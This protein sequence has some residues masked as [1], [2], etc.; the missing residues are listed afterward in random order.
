MLIIATGLIVII[1]VLAL[2]FIQAG[3]LTA[4]WSAAA[5]RRD[6]A[7]SAA[8]DGMEYAMARLRQTPEAIPGVSQTAANACDDWTFRDGT[9]AWT[10]RVSLAASPGPS[11]IRGEPWTDNPL[12]PNFQDDDGD[13]L[14][15]ETG[16]GTGIFNPAVD[17]WA[18]VDGDG[19]FTAYS[20]RLRG[21]RTPFSRLF[22]LRVKA[23]QSM[24]CVNSG[25]LGLS[26][27]DQD[28]DGILNESDDVFN[29]NT[30]PQVYEVFDNPRSTDGVYQVDP[31]G[32]PNWK[33]PSFYP[34]AH[35]VNILNNLGT[36]LAL[37]LPTHTENML[38]GGT[39][40]VSD[41]GRLVIGNRPRGGYSSIEELWPI[42]ENAGLTRSQFD[43]LAP[44]L[45]T[46]GEIVPVG[47]STP[48]AINPFSDYAVQRE[49]WIEFHAR[50]DLNNVPPPILQAW[51]Y[52]MA[53]S[54]S[55]WDLLNPYIP[56]SKIIPGDG[57]L[58]ADA[59][60]KDRP[61]NTWKRLLNTVKQTTLS[62]TA[63]VD[64][65]LIGDL[66]LA[67]ADANS[68]VVDPFSWRKSCLDVM[69][70][71]SPRYGNDT[72]VM[73][74]ISRSL[75][76]TEPFV[77]SVD[78]RVS[79]AATFAAS[80]QIYTVESEGC[81]RREGGGGAEGSR[82][83]RSELDVGGRHILLTSQQ[84][85]ERLTRTLSDPGASDIWRSPGGEVRTEGPCQ[86]RRGIQSWPRFPLTGPILTKGDT[87]IPNYAPTAIDPTGTFLGYLSGVPKS[88]RYPSHFGDL[89]LS[90]R[91]LTDDDLGAGGNGC[92]F[93]LPFNEDAAGNAAYSQSLY[94]D[95]IAD[96]L[97]RS[98]TPAEF[99][100]SQDPATPMVLD[101][102]PIG[103]EQFLQGIQYAPGGVRLVGALVTIPTGWHASSGSHQIYRWNGTGA[104]GFPLLRADAVDPNTGVTVPGG[105]EI[106]AGTIEFWI[107]Q[108]AGE[109]SVHADYADADTTLTCE[110][111]GDDGTGDGWVKYFTIEIDYRPP[112]FGAGSAIVGKFF[113][114]TNNLPTDLSAPSWPDKEKFNL[115][116]AGI[117]ATENPVG[118]PTWRHVAVAFEDNGVPG[119]FTS[120][121]KVYIDG[122]LASAVT[123][124]PAPP[125][126]VSM[127]VSADP[128]EFPISVY[129]THAD[130]R[131]LVGGGFVDD[132]RFFSQTFDQAAALA[133]AQ[134]PR[135][136]T[137]P[138][139]GDPNGVYTSPLYIFD[140]QLFP[141]GVE[142]RGAAW[143]AFLPGDL[144]GSID[145][146]ITATRI[147]GSSD[148]RTFSW[149]GTGSPRIFFAAPITRVRSVDVKI[150]M[151]VS[152]S[153]CLVTGVSVLRDTPVLE[154][155][156]LIYGEPHSMRKSFGAR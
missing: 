97:P 146:T 10:G 36:V 82:R 88:Y 152:A 39:I 110:Y 77:S 147:D 27:G 44:Y 32:I 71:E 103:W 54:T 122:Q 60:L 62:V 111:R 151:T 65:N 4:G 63:T 80:S 114:W 143:D 126:N 68:Y 156:R 112:P 7:A 91:Q 18:D 89:R 125:V 58:L 24:I 47:V 31:A 129:P 15:D 132:I 1:S 35:I 55:H 154:E 53:S 19:Q 145:Y 150:E 87:P 30:N 121:V 74:Q 52:H 142:L 56:Y 13:G 140:E 61:Y 85:F 3:R 84:D 70:R 108:R 118:K 106:L 133:A 113:L 72:S 131:F 83:L 48:N 51:L 14:I 69:G 135:Y 49:S 37:G 86:E 28:M 34:N 38:G 128:A 96:P 6:A 127:K 26:T 124:F 64:K 105:G 117:P 33:D 116:D 8:L 17:T 66:I 95:N 98:V 59:I 12:A 41:L 67:N 123:T 109:Q 148:T 94:T 81:L 99:A 50:L 22:Y 134:E 93:A 42:L 137:P 25:E 78:P 136:A 40:T 20:G 115:E 23:A 2:L 21:G 57:D 75:F 149:N 130:M 120:N 102:P 155:F 46:A 119:D 9:R 45:T 76:Y 139:V 92:V 29:L 100:M 11:Y 153:A 79:P 107:P 141:Q 16:E 101:P 104:N 144:T 73:R 43:L 5:L 90:A 138:G